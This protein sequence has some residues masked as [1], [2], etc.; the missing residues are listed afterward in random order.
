MKKAFAIAKGTVAEFSEDNVLRL[1]AALAYYSI[2]SL[3]PLLIIMVGLAGF[4]L[5]EGTV[6]HEIIEQLKSFFGERSAQVLE[7]MMTVHSKKSGLIT[8][9]VGVVMLL[10]G[11]SGVFGQLQD[12]LNTIW[13]VKSQP[14][15]GI[16]AFLRNRFLSFSMV[17][18]IGFL[19]L[20]SMVLTTVLT[21]VTGSLN[22]K[23]AISEFLA[24]L[25]TFFV[26]FAV[27]TLLF[28]MIFKILPDVKIRW[29]DVWVGAIGTALLFTAG[30][31]LLAL[32]L[33]RES[34]ISA[35]GAAGPVVLI[36]LWVY[37][38]SVI[39]FLGAEFTQVYTK[40]TGEK[41]VPTQYAVPITPEERAEQ[42]IP[43]GDEKPEQPDKRPRQQPNK[44]GAPE[45]K[46]EATGP[47]P[48]IAVAQMRRSPTPLKPITDHPW[49][50]ASFALTIGMA[51][52]ALSRS[53]VLKVVNKTRKAF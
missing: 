41:V 52:G 26:N 43:K 44:A 38:A 25:V 8:T 3:G 36:F 50:F 14:G 30:K 49:R 17:L 51:M 19:L 16:L 33:G 53:G 39:L 35:Y 45:L 4:F 47:L 46:P 27:I 22:H 6:R 15:K 2:F 7:S 42:G 48:T 18:G 28:A 24:H 32:Y 34:T 21:S 31:Y 20:V 29:R 23:L 5:G 12:A 13:E 9:I 1:S 37:Y 11:A 40:Q 10:L